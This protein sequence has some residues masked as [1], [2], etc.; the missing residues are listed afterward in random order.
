MRASEKNIYVIGIYELE[1]Y[2]SKKCEEDFYDQVQTIV[3]MKERKK[4]RKNE[5]IVFMEDFNAR[6]EEKISKELIRKTDNEW[7]ISG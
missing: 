7:W 4:V 1:D 5:K 2:K 3:E 6:I